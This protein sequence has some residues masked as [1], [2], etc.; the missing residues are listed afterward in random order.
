MKFLQIK[1]KKKI[2]LNNW[3]YSYGL[4]EG[5]THRERVWRGLELDH[6][7][8][9]CCWDSGLEKEAGPHGLG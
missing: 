3:A 9:C 7:T 5:K 2:A 1:K 4:D 6:R 8:R